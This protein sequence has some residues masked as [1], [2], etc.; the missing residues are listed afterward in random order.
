LQVGEGYKLILYAWRSADQD[1]FRRRSGLEPALGHCRV[2]TEQLWYTGRLSLLP[3]QES[4][5]RITMTQE[6]P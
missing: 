2:A 6:S 1:F 3:D 5:P 4:V